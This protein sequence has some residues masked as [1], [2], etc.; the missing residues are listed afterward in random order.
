MTYLPVGVQHKAVLPR[1]YYLI[2]GVR[3]FS[4]LLIRIF[5]ITHR[6][7]SVISSRAPY[8][9]GAAVLFLHFPRRARRLFF[10]PHNLQTALPVGWL[11]SMSMISAGFV[12]FL[13]AAHNTASSSS[14]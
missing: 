2:F 11:P 1:F 10:Y 12:F 9:S 6:F 13:K 4:L 5:L 3:D 8:P 14:V 7:L